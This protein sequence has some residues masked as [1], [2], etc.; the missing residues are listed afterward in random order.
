MDINGALQNEMQS[1]AVAY[2]VL[3]PCSIKLVS[4]SYFI[5]HLVGKLVHIVHANAGLIPRPGSKTS[6]CACQ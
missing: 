6:V 5:F 4:E 1:S 3:Y 2:T